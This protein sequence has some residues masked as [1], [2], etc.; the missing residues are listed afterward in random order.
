M[1]WNIVFFLLP[2]SRRNVCSCCNRFDALFHCAFLY[3]CK[4][5]KRLVMMTVIGCDGGCDMLIVE[6]MN[7]M[8]GYG[9]K[10]NMII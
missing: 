8:I 3:C 5:N 1:I 10:K 9:D 4:Y 6:T 7:F 2:L